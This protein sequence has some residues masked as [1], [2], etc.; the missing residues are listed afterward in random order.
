MLHILPF[1]VLILTF[2]HL[3]CTPFHNSVIVY[4]II[5]IFGPLILPFPCSFPPIYN[6]ILSPD[7]SFMDPLHH[8]HIMPD[9]PKFYSVLIY[10]QK[11]TLC[12]ISFS[13]FLSLCIYPDH[14]VALE[15]A[16]ALNCVSLSVVF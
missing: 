10:P 7:L 8:S 3:N 6:H 13:F 4:C 9:L 5:N 16:H 2:P 1:L 14:S 15:R 11:I 12:H